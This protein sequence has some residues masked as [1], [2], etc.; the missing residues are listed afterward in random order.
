MNGLG[1]IS[2]TRWIDPWKGPRSILFFRIFSRRDGGTREAERE[3][4]FHPEFPCNYFLVRLFG[5]NSTLLIPLLR[6][7]VVARFRGKMKTAAAM[8]LRCVERKFRY[9]AGGGKVNFHRWVVTEGNWRGGRGNR[10]CINRRR[11]EISKKYFA[12]PSLDQIIHNRIG[13]VDYYSRFCTWP[14]L[15]TIR[16]RVFHLL[17]HLC[18]QQSLFHLRGWEKKKRIFDRAINIRFKISSLQ[19]NLCPS[20]FFFFK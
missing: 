19:F 6:G 5:F 2:I 17:G 20:F 7:A 4:E 13:D 18:R 12:P 10:N 16:G 1:T 8:L 9:G 15:V 14:I 3:R 11:N